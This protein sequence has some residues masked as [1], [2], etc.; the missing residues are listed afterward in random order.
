MTAKHSSHTLAITFALL[1]AGC[2]QAGNSAPEAAWPSLDEAPASARSDATPAELPRPCTLVT[3][4]DAQAVIGSEVGEMANDQ[5]VCMWAGGDSP[6]AITMLMVQLMRA[7][8]EDE[9]A[10]LFDNLTGLSGN[11]AM[12]VNDAAGT[13]TRKSGQDIEGLGDAAWCSA[14][15]AD[16]VGSQQ[17]IVRSGTVLLTLNVTGMTKG[18]RQASLCPKLEAAARQAF[19]RLGGAP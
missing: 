3:A 7:D 17:V 19:A 12:A 5:D 1:L 6:G 16:L 2:S 8:S 10:V 15:N 14:S 4:D 9:T 11:L 18:E 13:T